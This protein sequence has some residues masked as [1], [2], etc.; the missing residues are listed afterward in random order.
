MELTSEQIVTNLLTKK[1][2]ITNSKTAQYS[3]MPIYNLGNFLSSNT[4]EKNP[5][6][7]KY[8]FIR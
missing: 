7:G 1:E 3:T 5:Y 4:F 6:E 2:I 8:V